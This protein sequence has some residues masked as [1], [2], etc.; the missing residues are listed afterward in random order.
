[1]WGR[2][3]EVYIAIIAAALFVFETN[4]DKPL[5]SRF[6]ITM[7]SAGFGFSL[8]PDLAEQTGQSLVL[9]GI[10]V[11][12]LGFLVLE[13]SV[14]LLSDTAFMKKIIAKRVGVQT[15]EGEDGK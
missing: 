15:K 13:V 2:P 3:I 14:A 12:A 11:T 8:G 4:K 7:S 6:L 5:W 10:I 1:M 9:T